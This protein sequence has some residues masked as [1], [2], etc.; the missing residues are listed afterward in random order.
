MTVRGH[1]ECAALAALCAADHADLGHLGRLHRGAERAW[2]SGHA[3]LR[4]V[5]ADHDRARPVRT[6]GR[7]APAA[8]PALALLGLAIGLLGAGGQ[9]LL[10]RA[11]TLGP[12]YL[13][14][15]I[16]SLSPVVTIVLSL[17]AAGRAHR[18]ARRG[19]HQ[20]GR[21]L[22]AAVRLC[23]GR[24]RS[25]TAR[26]F[27][28]ALAV[29][30]AWGLQAYFIKLANATMSAESIFWYMMLTGLAFIPVAWLLTDFS[31]PINL[32]LCGPWLAAAIQMLNAVGALLLVYA[33]RYGK[34]IVV[35]PLMNAGAPLLT[36][37]ISLAV[38][39]SLPGSVQARGAWYWRWAARCCCRCSPNERSGAAH[40]GAAGV[41]AAPQ[42]R[43]RRR[44]ST[45]CAPRTRWSSRRRC[46]RRTRGPPC[47][48]RGDLQPGQPV[49]WLQ[50]HEARRAS[51]TTSPALPRAWACRRSACCSAA[52]TWGRTCGAPSPR[53]APWRAPSNW[54]RTTSRPDFARSTSTA[55]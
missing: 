7:C 6:A 8:R 34:A 11:V 37:L 40:E 19:R 31:R 20:A 13:I 52:T 49:R 10:F 27:L 32:G 1:R 24:A 42:G 21:H 4:G 30:L 3:D 9:M 54:S 26:W 5:G 35:S 47:A 12:T 41:A 33:F 15:P 36:S 2:L 17:A 16:V 14:F 22:A 46:A 38:A 51:A 44:A 25:T 50:R 39:G 23:A 48:D 45:R 18:H 28:L 43:Q 29:M 55:R 53:R